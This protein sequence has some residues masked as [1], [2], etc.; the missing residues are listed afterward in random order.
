[1]ATSVLGAKSM[2]IGPVEYLELAFPGNQFKGEILPA[3]QELVVNDTINIID[4]VIV[5]KDAD[6]SITIAELSE[7]DESEA[8]LLAPLQSE[9]RD[10]LNEDDIL[11]L[12]EDLPD[13]YTAALLVWENRW[14]T[15]FAEAV[16]NA[17][18]IMVANE[19]VPH[20]V[21]MAAIEAGNA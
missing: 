18:G 9:L 13:N 1:M 4:L 11:M 20:D 21:V 8:A 10:L 2:S 7:L 14:A 19:R 3:L 5:K 12:A 16:R 6:G 15:R 17:G